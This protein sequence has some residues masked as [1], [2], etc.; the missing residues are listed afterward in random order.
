MSYS[1]NLRVCCARTRKNSTADCYKR[2][3]PTVVQKADKGFFGFYCPQDGKK[4][5]PVTNSS[6]SAELNSADASILLSII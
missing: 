5:A 6:I 2:S 3:A 4:D 1:R